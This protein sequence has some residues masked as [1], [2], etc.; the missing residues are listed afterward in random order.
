MR[1]PKRHKEDAYHRLVDRGGRHAK[2]HGFAGSGMDAIAAA[3]GV[4]SGSLYRHFDGKSDLFAA[5]VEHELGR[6]AAAYRDLSAHDRRALLAAFDRYLSTAHLDH[7]EAGCVLPTLTAEVARADTR[8]RARFEA[9]VIEIHGLLEQVTGSRQ[10]AWVLLA[11]IVG[12]VM[13]ARAMLDAEL[14]GHVLASV[15]QH[16]QSLLGAG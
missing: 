6:A 8:V 5:I 12:A 15:Q 16:C 14:R 1:Y 3:A 9:G 11:Q 10:Q 4:T 7:P 2:R 13:I